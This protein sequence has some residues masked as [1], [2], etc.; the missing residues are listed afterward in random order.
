MEDDLVDLAKPGDRVK[1]VGIFKCFAGMGTSGDG[2][3]RSALLGLSVNQMNAE[4]DEMNISL[5]DIKLIE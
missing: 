5:E 1:I 4:N 3:F 2:S